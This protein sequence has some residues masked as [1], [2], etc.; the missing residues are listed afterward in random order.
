[1][2][3]KLIKSPKGDKKFRAVLIDINRHVDF[4]GK[5][6]SDFTLHKEPE[7]MRLYV[8]RHGG[9]V[10]K[11]MRS[12]RKPRDIIDS[13][14]KVT[15]SDKERW[16]KKGIDT[17]GFWSRWLLWSYPSLEKAKTFMS[18]KFGIQFV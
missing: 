9:L 12:I 13:L 7:R 15:T 6:Y 3:V 16:T 5:G 17:A 2:R 18:K 11:K 4:G 1:M 10:T 8:Q 14:I